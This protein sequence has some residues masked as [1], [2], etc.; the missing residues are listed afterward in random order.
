[1]ETMFLVAGLAVAG[2]AGILAAIYFSV[3]AGKRGGKR[4]RPTGPGRIGAD[5][6]GASRTGASRAGAVRRPGGRAALVRTGGQTEFALRASG[7]T[8]SAPGPGRPAADQ[9][10]ARAQAGALTESW[11]AAPSDLDDLQSGDAW[12]DDAWP[13]DSTATDPGL[14]AARP[15]ADLDAPGPAK[16][17]SGASRDARSRRRGFRKGAD[18]DE[19]L[20]PADSFGGVSDEQFWDDLASD[21]PLTT[22][23]RTAQQ[24][25]G[26]RSRLLDTGSD[27]DPQGTQAL[28]GD[29]SGPGQA[30]SDRSRAD[31]SRTDQGRADQGRAAGEGRR[32]AGYGAYPGP[33]TGT[34][35]AAERTVVQSAYAAT[36]PVKS[37]TPP[38]APAAPK[39]FPGVPQPVKSTAPPPGAT[40]PVRAASSTG[41]SSTGPSSTGPSST[42]P[43]STGPSSTGLSG[44]GSAGTGPAGTGSSGTA[45][46]P[47]GASA[48][49]AETGRRRRP[50]GPDEDPLTSASFSLRQRGPVDGRSSLR[51]RD[52]QDAPRD[53]DAAGGPGREPAAGPYGHTTPY[54]PAPAA[55]SYDDASSVTQMM[56]TPPYGE[57]YGSGSQADHAGRRNGTRSHARPAGA[58]TGERPRP[59]RPAYPQDVRQASGSYP[60]GA[61]PGNGHQ[62]HGHQPGGYPGNSYPGNGYAGNGYPGSGQPDGG[63]QG[64]GYPDSGH[65]GGS[66]PGNGS[67]GHGH[68]A[69]HDPRDDYRRLTHRRLPSRL[70]SCPKETWSGRPPAAC[71]RRWRDGR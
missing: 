59:T 53:R 36:Q 1:M 10:P 33:R 28:G 23:A 71:T 30:R 41:P 32:S 40:Q 5:R 26:P 51:S 49:P 56:S 6:A 42:G 47:R 65:Q 54:S 9:R 48:P 20:W 43:S 14:R 19:E 31:R 66:N 17:G 13:G 15:G 11:P 27:T 68:R 29:R 44:T 18:I 64:S 38:S 69:P 58:D 7:P 2:V 60:A 24:D 61:Y 3:R 16:P 22:T 57:K 63:H 4:L 55:T 21:K 12:P 70:R 8:R 39:P 37:M 46:Q 25:A 50:S 34:D 35:P 67:R 62:G 52:Q 45:G